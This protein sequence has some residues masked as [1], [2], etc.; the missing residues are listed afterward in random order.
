MDAKLGIIFDIC[1]QNGRKI[2]FPYKIMYA[3]RAVH[4]VIIF[5]IRYV[6][7]KLYVAKHWIWSEK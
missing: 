1:K 3:Q 5:S 7:C 2:S 6:F 4:V